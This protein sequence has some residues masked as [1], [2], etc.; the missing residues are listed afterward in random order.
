MLLISIGL[1]KVNSWCLSEDLPGNKWGYG[2]SVEKANTT[3]KPII[4][5]KLNKITQRI[6]FRF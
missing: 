4:I 1:K 2:Q 6:Y 3:S 5:A